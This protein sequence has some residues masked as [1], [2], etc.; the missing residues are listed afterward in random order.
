MNSFNSALKPDAKQEVVPLFKVSDS[1]KEDSNNDDSTLKGLSLVNDDAKKHPDRG[2]S[3]SKP[4][5]S[6]NILTGLSKLNKDSK[7]PTTTPST[8]SSSNQ[9]PSSSTSSSSPTALTK[10]SMHKILTEYYT[11]NDPKRLDT[12]PSLLDKYALDYPDLL[13]KFVKKYGPLESLKNASNTTT[14]VKPTT[15]TTTPSPIVPTSSANSSNTTSSFFANTGSKASSTPSPIVPASSKAESATS[16]NTTNSF[17]VNAGSKGSAPTPFSKQ[18][19]SPATSSSLF[20]NSGISSPS[21]LNIAPLKSQPLTNFSMPNQQAISSPSITSPFSMA[22]G[23][24]LSG[25]GGGMSSPFQT[26]QTGTMTRE[27]MVEILTAYYTRNDPEKLDKIPNLILKYATNFGELLRQLKKKYG[28]IPLNENTGNNSINNAGTGWSSAGTGTWGSQQQPV[29]NNMSSGIGGGVM[30]IMKTGS[31]PLQ[32]YNLQQ[33]QGQGS[34]TGQVS[35]FSQS[36]SSL[37]NRSSTFQQGATPFANPNTIS[38]PYAN[39]GA[40]S[41]F[42]S[43]FNRPSSGTASPFQST[44]S[45]GINNPSASPFASNTTPLGRTSPVT[46]SFYNQSPQNN[47]SHFLNVNTS[48]TSNMGNS[49]FSMNNSDMVSPLGSPFGSNNNNNMGQQPSFNQPSGFRSSLNQPSGFGQ[50]SALGN[51]SGFG[52]QQ[53]QSSRFGQQQQSQPSGF[54]QQQQLQSSGFGQ[55]SPL[56]Q[57]MGGQENRFGSGFGQ[58]SSLSSGVP[59]RTILGNSSM[60]NQSI[61]SSGRTGT[62]ST[63]FRR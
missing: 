21:T 59:N 42:V 47:S 8:P 48:M 6:I 1:N 19:A 38:T 51:T 52:Q 27:K 30:N 61:N 60:F 2:Q 36:P 17:F 14:P 29:N 39:P 37:F 20:S 12:I 58:P 55:T 62:A 23:S 7:G 10:E 26:G 63:L 28:D 44:S 41:S 32:N 53:S 49:P 16:S 40:G 4:T 15:G 3:N 50:T 33:G 34:M 56:G 46:S 22:S 13:S 5:E 11:M 43:T 31:A 25:S 57:Q 9:V 24:A 54:G 18:S 35:P 45:G